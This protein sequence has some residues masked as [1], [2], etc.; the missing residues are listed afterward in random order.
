MINDFR[1][2]KERAAIVLTMMNGA[3]LSGDL[4]V[5]PS[6]RTRQGPAD[7]PGVL[8]APEPF[9]PMLTDTG[10]TYLIAKERVREVALGTD[11]RDDEEWRVGAPATVELA[12]AGGAVYRGVLYLDTVMSGRARVLDY[13]NRV[14]D[15]F[16]TLHTMGGTLL[17]NRQAIERVHPID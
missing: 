10:E 13:L 9:F 4:F 16:L 2:E 1:I 12:L 7:A 6:V 15:H 11:V 17:I 5:Q 8:N 14:Q 3:R